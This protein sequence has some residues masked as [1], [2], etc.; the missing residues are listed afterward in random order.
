MGSMSAP[1]TNTFANL[2]AF[3]PP[4]GIVVLHGA[5]PPPETHNTGALE[6]P[7]AAKVP[8]AEK[9]HAGCNRINLALGGVQ[10]QSQARATEVAQLAKPGV[11]SGL[12]VGEKQEVIGTAQVFAD[13]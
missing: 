11:Q 10:V 8:K 5:Q 6:P 13:R 4:C 3:C 9:W 1:T 12:V 7:V 2:F